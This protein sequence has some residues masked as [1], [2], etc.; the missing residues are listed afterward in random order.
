VGDGSHRKEVLQLLNEYDEAHIF[1]GHT[2]Y[3][4]PYDYVWYNTGYNI[5]EHCIASTRQDMIASNIHRDGTPCGYNIFKIRGN[6]IVDWYYK[7]Y[8]HGMNTR[9]YQMRLY[10][11]ASIFGAEPTGENKYGTMGYYQFPF[12]NGTLL[13]NI[14]SSDP[15][16]KV[17]VYEDGVYSGAMTHFSQYS[18]SDYDKLVGDGT[19][20]SPRRVADGV[21]CSRDFWA[22]GVLFGRLGSNV[23]NNYNVCHT[24]WRYE[25]KNPAAKHIEVRAT[26]R[27][28]YEYRCD[29]IE[30]NSDLGYA[31]YDPQYNPVIE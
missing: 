28:G 3:M 5:Y 12:D 4:R 11:G 15:S 6:K 29:R 7:G 26:D 18:G 17:E 16:W 27:F 2:H 8:P 14:F 23:G 24:M 30:D 19:L 13:A 25:L 20:A 1:S 10:R 31:M 21:V 9:D 22:I